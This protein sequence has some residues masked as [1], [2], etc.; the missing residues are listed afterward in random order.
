MKTIEGEGV[1]VD[2]SELPFICSDYGG[3]GNFLYYQL[4]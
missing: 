4:S 2:T 3:L 1:G